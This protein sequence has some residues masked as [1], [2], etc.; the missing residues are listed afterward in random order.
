MSS[1]QRSHWKDGEEDARFTQQSVQSDQHTQ[2]KKGE[3]VMREEG[4][5]VE[6]KSLR[7]TPTATTSV[8]TATRKK[9]LRGGRIPGRTIF[10]LSRH[11]REIKPIDDAHHIR[12]CNNKQSEV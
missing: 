10:S 4:K 2:G 9:R 11:D 8:K 1:Q 6:R 12:D 3:E 7:R 5:I